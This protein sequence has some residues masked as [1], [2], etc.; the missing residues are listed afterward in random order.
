[1]ASSFIVD[2]LSANDDA[3]ELAG[4]FYGEEVIGEFQVVTSGGTAEFGRALSG[5]VN[6]V[7]RGRSNDFHG[8]IYGFLRNQRFD[9][10]TRLSRTNCL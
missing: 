6:I 10:R 3:A 2:G 7:T 8:D 1:L 9:A 5:Y 4:T